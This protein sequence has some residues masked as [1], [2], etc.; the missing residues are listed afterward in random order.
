MTY[1]RLLFGG[2]EAGRTLE[3]IDGDGERSERFP[4]FGFVRLGARGFR[5]ADLI[6]IISDLF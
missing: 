3:V 1:E 2:V 6:D 4:A 5:L